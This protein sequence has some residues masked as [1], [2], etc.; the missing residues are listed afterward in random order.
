MTGAR[1]EENRRQRF[2]RGVTAGYAD[3]AIAAASTKNQKADHWNVV[4]RLDGGLTFWTS[5][6][7]EDNRLFTRNAMNDD[8]EEATDDPADHAEEH[9]GN[10]QRHIEGAIYRRHAHLGEHCITALE[11]RL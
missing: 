8:V 11:C 6:V 2:D 4:I 9:A 5:G 1:H 10:W 3:S 7:R